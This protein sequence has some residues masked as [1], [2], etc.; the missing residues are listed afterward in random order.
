MCCPVVNQLLACHPPIHSS[1]HLPNHP[2]T[3]PPPTTRPPARLPAATLTTPTAAPVA[4][5]ELRWSDSAVV[6]QL[7]VVS[8][9]LLPTTALLNLKDW[10]AT[11][12]VPTGLKY[13]ALAAG[14]GLLPSSPLTGPAFQASGMVA[15][16]VLAPRTRMHS[17]GPRRG[18]AWSAP[19]RSS[20][21]THQPQESHPAS[22]LATHIHTHHTHPPPHHAGG[23]ICP[24]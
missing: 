4:L 19:H 14:L 6:G 20:S 16:R 8:S 24:K 5:H 10:N 2:P 21:L 15:P 17:P 9:L 23:G 11:V 13:T 12:N 18:L 1:T 7:H 22:H 3:H